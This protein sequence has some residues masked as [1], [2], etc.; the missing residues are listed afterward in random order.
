MMYHQII[1]GM[2]AHPRLVKGI[3]IMS[4]AALLM[5]Q[6]APTSCNGGGQISPATQQSVDA[7]YNVVCGYLP[8]LEPISAVMD[9]KAQNALAQA[10]LICAAGS[11]TNPVAAG[12]DILA[13]YVALSPY[14][15]HVKA[16]SALHVQEMAVHHQLHAEGK[17]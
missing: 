5:G 14:F 12:V 11:P 15:T 9:A 3:G 10:K 8:A 4:L 7:A 6:A 2:K 16:T 1:E 17:I 13:L